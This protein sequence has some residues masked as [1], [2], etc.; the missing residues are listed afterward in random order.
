MITHTTTNKDTKQTKNTCSYKQNSC[1]QDDVPLTLV[2]AASSY[3]H[4]THEQQ[5][6]TEDGEDVRGSD[7]A[8][9]ERERDR[10]RKR[11]ERMIVAPCHPSW[12]ER[13]KGR[14]K[15]QS[16]VTWVEERKL[17]THLTFS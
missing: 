1:P 6:G 16:W 15:M 13:G 3:T 11:K 14:P 4:T 2:E 9:R 10:E 12:S 8:C 17:T 5:D 7:H